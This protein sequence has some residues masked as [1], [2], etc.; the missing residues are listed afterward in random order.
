MCY[1]HV[2]D[3]DQCEQEATQQASYLDEFAAFYA[4]PSNMYETVPVGGDD[5]EQDP[6]N[7]YELI[8]VGGD[9][10]TVYEDGTVYE[11]P[12]AAGD[13]RDER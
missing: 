10:D 1:G 13:A 2:V 3:D 8:P 9:D 4:D 5:D 7:L 11:D 12:G 6:S